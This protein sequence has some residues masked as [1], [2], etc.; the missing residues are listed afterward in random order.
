V[1]AC[2][3]PGPSGESALIKLN[4]RSNLLSGSAAEVEKCT[5]LIQLDISHN[6]F[7][8]SVPASRRW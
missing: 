3:L 5:N 4:V 8:G 2:L 7:T 6:L 1:L